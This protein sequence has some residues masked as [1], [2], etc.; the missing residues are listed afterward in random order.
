MQPPLPIP[1]ICRL[2][3][4]SSARTMPCYN[5]YVSRDYQTTSGTSSNFWTEKKK[6]LRTTRKMITA[7]TIQCA[8]TP[9]TTVAPKT[10]EKPDSNN[11]FETVSQAMFP[12]P[13]Q[14]HTDEVQ[15]AREE[16]AERQGKGRTVGGRPAPRA[17]EALG[18]DFFKRN[19]IM[20]DQYTV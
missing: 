16:A 4:P 13:M 14:R 15:A 9:V 11:M 17:A 10:E 7:D 2:E 5:Q 6:E 20:R 19:A 18:K 3:N 12:P 8:P 1:R